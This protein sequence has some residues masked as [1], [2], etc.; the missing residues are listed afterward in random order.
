[1]NITS[2]TDGGLSSS[3]DAPSQR[4][5]TLP[6]PTRWSL[7][8]SP[9]LLVL[10]L[11]TASALATVATR[12]WTAGRAP[13]IPGFNWSQHPNSLLL[14]TPL[15]DACSTCNLSLAGWATL[16]FQSGFDVVVVAARPTIE[17][18]ALRKQFPQARLSIVTDVAEAT[19]KR[20]SQGD[21]IGGVLIRQGR[22]LRQQRGGT[23]P[24]SFFAQ[25]AGTS[26]PGR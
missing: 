16:G 2:V 15:A 17:L 21:K 5:V 25:P 26:G 10:L 22:I 6:R 13:S 1:M 19:I 18:K 23:P 4:D 3:A 9:Y 20:F 11:L 12:R 7:L 8:S 14:A 24:A